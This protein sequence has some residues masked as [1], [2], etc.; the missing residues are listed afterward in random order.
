MLITERKKIEQMTKLMTLAFFLMVSIT[1]ALPIAVEAQGFAGAPVPYNYRQD[2][3]QMYQP[4]PPPIGSGEMAPPVEP[5]DL[6]PALPPPS[7][8]ADQTTGS[9]FPTT[10][11]K[12]RTV[13]YV[14]VNGR[15]MQTIRPD[16]LTDPEIKEINKI[17]GI[18]MLSGQQIIEVEA[19]QNQI[20]QIQQV[21]MAWPR[22]WR[23]VNHNGR[24]YRQIV[25][26]EPAAGYPKPGR[27]N[28][29]AFDRNKGKW[30]EVGQIEKLPTVKV[31]A[32]YLV[33]L[34]C[35]CACVWLSHEAISVFLG[36]P[37]AGMRVAQ[38]FFGLG[39]LLMAFTI[40]KLV[41]I[42]AIHSFGAPHPHPWVDTS[43]FANDLHHTAPVDDKYLTAPDVPG[44][45]AEDRLGPERA[46]V[47]VEPLGA[48]QY[49]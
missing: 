38:T 8:Q 7:G 37:G 9:V 34:G 26:D 32:R 43:P 36:H 44:I 12:D 35:V 33:I 5:G 13:V 3:T 16:Q 31:F 30:V 45:P 2:D 20:S 19:T 42:E 46:G 28:T 40:Y 18:N 6:G 11:G 29:G 24:M 14:F 49:E 17:L 25:K 27:E 23:M 1:M 22:G 48:P 10:V 15:M 4:T 21:M 41:Q 39:V 47:P